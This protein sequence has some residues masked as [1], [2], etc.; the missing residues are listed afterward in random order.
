MGIKS[1]QGS[2]RQQNTVEPNALKVRDYMTTN[3]IT[4]TADQS[5]QDVVEAL[6]KFKISGGPVVNDK[7]ELVGIISEG[8]CLKQL[9]ES[10]YYNMPLDH[11]NVEKRMAKDVETIDGNMNVFDAANKFLQSKRRRFPIVENGKLIGQIS[12]KDILKAALNL[13][14]VNWN[15]TTK[16]NS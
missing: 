14:G 11:D 3:L 16:G 5:V 15:S 12:Q 6:I 4:F 8:D 10:R 1:F 9:S 2:R 7:N 13:K